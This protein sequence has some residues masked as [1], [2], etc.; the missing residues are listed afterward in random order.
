MKHRINKFP[1]RLT[2]HAHILPRWTALAA[3]A[4][5]S[6]PALSPAQTAN[7]AS[8][9]MPVAKPAAANAGLLNDWLRTQSSQWNAWDMGGEVRARYEMFD[10]GS[11]A[12]PANDFQLKGAANYNSYLWTREKVH[13]GYT[14]PWFK[15]YAEGRNSD[16]SSDADPRNLGEDSFDL[17]QAYLILG[18]AKEFPLTVKAGRQEMIYGDERILGASDWNNTAR[19]FDAVKLRYEDKSLWVDAFAG[20]V[21]VPVD[22]KFNEA[23]HHDWLFGLYASST[24]LIPIQESQLYFLSRNVGQGSAAG[25]SPRDIYTPGLRVKSLPGKLKGWDYTAEVVKQFGNIVQSGVRR[26]QDAWAA[27]VGGGFT[28]TDVFASP[29]VGL[30]YNFSSGDSNSKDGKSQTLDNLFS[31]IKISYC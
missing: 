31:F 13:V 14:A 4:M 1:R 26:E 7:P 17:H 12:A 22:G 20:R 27:S 28:W 19:V 16:A 18:N 15:A 24:T 30:E 3:T 2:A 11:P 23:D 29:R 5:A 8:A 9:A 6:W 21:V 25:T 10:G